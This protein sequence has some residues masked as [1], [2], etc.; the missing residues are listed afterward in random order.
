MQSC[1]RGDEVCRVRHEPRSRWPG[2]FVTRDGT[3]PKEP[4]VAKMMTMLIMAGIIMS[5]GSEKAT[6]MESKLEPSLRQMLSSPDASKSA[7]ML[8]IFGKCT[9]TID[10][11]MREQLLDAGAT[12]E[13]VTG[14]IFTARVFPEAIAKLSSLEF[15]RQL[16][17]SHSS[18]PLAK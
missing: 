12:V 15:V 2:F 10:A 3:H 11:G 4:S 18:N 8:M 6:L 17:L 13:T 9:K 7:E 5:C 14:D 1:G 16:Q